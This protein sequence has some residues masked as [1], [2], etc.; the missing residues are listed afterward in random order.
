MLEMLCEL[1]EEEAARQARIHEAILA[2]REAVG[3]Q[4]VG[5]VERATETLKHLTGEAKAAEMRRALVI[6]DVVARLELPAERQNMS[7]IIAAAPEGLRHRL[8]TV[9]A[10]LKELLRATERL[11]RDQNVAVRRSLNTVDRGLRQLHVAGAQGAGAYDA[12]AYDARG[13]RTLAGAGDGRLN[14]RG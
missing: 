8:R 6:A 4:D 3:L 2:Q 7:G 12:G 5:R 14:A 1:L 10:R 11:V 13:E 9:Q